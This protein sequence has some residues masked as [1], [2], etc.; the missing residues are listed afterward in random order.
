MSVD[1]GI[2]MSIH[3]AL[4]PRRYNATPRRLHREQPCLPVGGDAFTDRPNDSAILHQCNFW[5]LDSTVMTVRRRRRQAA[6]PRHIANGDKMLEYGSLWY[7]AALTG[8]DGEMIGSMYM[9]D[10][11]DRDALE[12]W[13]AAEPYITEGVW[14]RIEVHPCSTR[15]PWQFNR[16]REFFERRK[17]P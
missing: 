10:F 4:M 17:K 6:R 15:D 12:E 11:N 16:P 2:D 3:S 8:D 9:V 1:S 5:C 7:G 14:Q 13:L